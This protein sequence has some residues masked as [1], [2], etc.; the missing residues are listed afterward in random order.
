MGRPLEN[1]PGLRLDGCSIDDKGKLN[2]NFGPA[3]YYDY[4]KTNLF[5]ASKDGQK[6]RDII[7]DIHNLKESPLSNNVGVICTVLTADNKI[8]LSR[9]RKTVATAGGQ[10]NSSFAEAMDFKRDVN[11]SGQPDPF[12]TIKRGMLEEYGFDVK[13]DN[14]KILGVILDTKYGAPSIIGSIQSDK[15]S[16]DILAQR[17]EAGSQW[18]DRHFFVDFSDEKIKGWLSDSRITWSDAGA[19]ALVVASKYLN[20]IK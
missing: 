20:K 2:L 17:K 10:Y 8:V 9:R 16:S 18:E 5:L 12:L 3:P 19:G 13:D 14:I 15:T 6:L 4:V 7:P 1:N 11:E